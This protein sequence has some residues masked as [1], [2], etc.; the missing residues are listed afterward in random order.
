MYS[1]ADIPE[2]KFK[3]TECKTINDDLFEKLLTGVMKLPRYSSSNNTRNRRPSNGKY[4][5][6]K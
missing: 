2:R 5:R 4:T 6:R 3:K 1:C